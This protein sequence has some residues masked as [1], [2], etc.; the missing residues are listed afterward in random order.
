MSQAP[1][2]SGLSL[3]TGAHT[4]TRHADDFYPTPAEVTEALVLTGVLPLPSAG[5]IWEPC[6]GDGAKAKVLQRHGWQVFGTDLVDRGYGLGGLDVLVA[7]LALQ[8]TVVTNPPFNIAGEI[9]EHLLARLGVETLALLLKS[10]FWH[11][12]SR[13]GLFARFPPVAVMPLL[14]RPDF[15]GRGAP[16]MECAWTVW[17]R[18]HAGATVYQPLSRPADASTGELFGVAA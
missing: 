13:A 15:D 5:P 7:P 18:G 6:C 8:P 11:A 3:A 12:S 2:L 16:V 9:I 1:S 14:W 10:Q 17:R 4:G